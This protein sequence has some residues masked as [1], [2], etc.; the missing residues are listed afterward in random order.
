MDN[1][2]IGQW[3]IAYPSPLFK[4]VNK[5]GEPKK[6]AGF[7]IEYGEKCVLFEGSAIPHPI[8]CI[9]AKG[10]Y[11]LLSSSFAQMSLSEQIDFMLTQKKSILVYLD[12]DETYFKFIDNEDKSED[13]KKYNYFSLRKELGDG[14][15]LLLFLQKLGFK[16]VHYIV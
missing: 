9:T 5:L 10:F 15:G 8:D 16:R 1:F 11:G 4:N 12:V 6:I 14:D 2:K 3:V 7:E 13:A